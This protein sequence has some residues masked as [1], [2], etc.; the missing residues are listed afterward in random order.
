MEEGGIGEAFC[1][2]HGDT[3]WPLRRFLALIKVIRW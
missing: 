3:S 2:F 1:S